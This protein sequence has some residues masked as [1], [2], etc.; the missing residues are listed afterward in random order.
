M[1][2]GPLIT[3]VSNDE[4]NG[5]DIE[6]C[7]TAV[8]PAIEISKWNLSGI[9][10]KYGD[11]CASNVGFHVKVPSYVKRPY[12]FPY[13]FIDEIIFKIQGIPV[14]ILQCSGK[15]L[16]CGFQ[17]YPDDKR[18]SIE[19]AAK[20]GM[21][22]LGDMLPPL[23]MLSSPWSTLTWNI[24]I[25]EKRYEDLLNDN[26]QVSD[27]AANGVEDVAGIMMKYAKLSNGIITPYIP[28]IYYNQQKRDKI[29]KDLKFTQYPRYIY[30]EIPVNV[31]YELN[32][33]YETRALQ[34]NVLI[35]RPDSF[36]SFYTPDEIPLKEFTL[37]HCSFS[38]IIKQGN[39]T[40]MY[41]MDKYTHNI[42]IPQHVA[43]YT[44]TLQ[45]FQNFESRKSQVSSF[46]DIRMNGISMLNLKNI[47]VKIT[48]EDHIPSSAK[49]CLLILCVGTIQY[50]GGTLSVK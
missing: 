37:R 2:S 50:S 21:I 1:S 8:G 25:N 32:I 36:L 13:L 48:T 42:Y 47:S 17:S 43:L 26:S 27:I 16:W 41:I 24:K 6:A 5:E 34:F 9:F 11:F 4:K 40:E 18:R 49:V 15:S 30:F 39:H 29:I 14:P 7:E 33:P 38:T 12:G 45:T 35:E 28:Y 3:L 23:S 46:N 22:M 20:H 19:L 31:E 44:H 10:K